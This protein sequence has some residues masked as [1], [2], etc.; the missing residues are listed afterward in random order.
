ME[1]LEFQV[2]IIMRFGISIRR[3]I[4]SILK[5]IGNSY[6]MEGGGIEQTSCSTSARFNK[7]HVQQTLCSRNA[8]FNEPYVLRRVCPMQLGMALGVPPLGQTLVGDTPTYTS[9]FDCLGSVW[10]L[11]SSG[12]PRSAVS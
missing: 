9:G 5:I 8:M 3:M 12:I 10:S 11:P 4:I 1:S 7:L 6:S 2:R